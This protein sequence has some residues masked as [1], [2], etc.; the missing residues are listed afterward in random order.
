MTFNGLNAEEKHRY[1]RWTLG[2]LLALAIWFFGIERRVAVIEERVTTIQ[3]QHTQAVK[4][5]E[6]MRTWMWTFVRREY[7]DP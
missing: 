5:V 4:Q 2:A 3:R 7:G 1:T 6:E